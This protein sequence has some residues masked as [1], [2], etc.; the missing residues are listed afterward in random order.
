MPNSNEVPLM[1]QA[2][3]SG[4][5]QIQY[6]QQ[7][8][9]SE[10]WVDEWLE[11]TAIDSPKFSDK[12]RTKPYQ[13]S[14]RLLSNSGQDDDF[15][16]P[17][18]AANGFPYYPGA[19]MK[20]AFL[21]HC[22]REQKIRYCGCE[23]NNETQPGYLRFH[24]AFPKDHSWK[25][26]PL[27]DVVHPQQDWQIK[28]SNSHSAF[29]Q[30][31]LYQPTLVFGISSTIEL[32][33]SEWEAIWSIWDK[34]IER[35]IG[36]RVSA[37]YGQPIKHPET[38]LITVS[39]KGQGL[40]SQL[41][42]RSGEFRPNMFKAALRGHT[43]R[44]FS[45]V[46]DENTAEELTKELWGGFAGAK[47]AI[48]GDLG[49]AFNA[50]DLEMNEFT[51]RRTV[52]MP[53]YDLQKGV[54]SIL[55][56]KNYTDEYKDKLKKLVVQILKFSML[57]GG[58]G[59]SS[60]R[61]DH[62]IFLPEYLEPGNKPMIGCHWQFTDKSTV[63]YFPVRNIENITK[64]IDSVK[65]SVNNWLIFKGKTPRNQISSWRESF[66][67]EKV[68]IWGRIAENEDDSLAIEWFHGN[69]NKTQSIK[70]SKL[71]GKMGNIGRIYHRMYPHHIK[72]SEGEIK[73]RGRE[74]IELLTIFPDKEDQITRE[75]LTF[76]PTTEFQ[77]LW[78]I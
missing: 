38:K 75:F 41:I 10:R 56:M 51:Y 11:A 5:G 37:G 15:I 55:C 19:S 61:I 34:A 35:G 58:F 14:W 60:R 16:R 21:R 46:T 64:I 69:Y 50:I 68:Q 40:A 66:H 52:K 33:E 12:V 78:G 62:R 8:E 13:I 30:I 74:Y 43:L 27:I 6:I 31:S 36:S 7:P 77:K 17:V 48:V 47:G 20:G 72:T 44:L 57:I 70:N 26:N 71:T 54:L 25:E 1:F 32:N 65:T 53:I 76:L 29:L 67:P 28:N 3:I 39:L 73:R 63:Y 59:K 2:Q 9:Q 4:R 45:A 49:I 22:N 42:D 18:I 24:G 23:I